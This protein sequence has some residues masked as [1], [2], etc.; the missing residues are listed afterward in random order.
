M[1]ILVSLRR[2]FVVPFVCARSLFALA[3]LA[4]GLA[5]FAQSPAQAPPAPASP[6]P[7]SPPAAAAATTPT[8]GESTPALAP[9]PAPVAPPPSQIAQPAAP[10]TTAELRTITAE[11]IK[12][13]LVGK[14][15]FL[16]GGYLDDTLHFDQHGQ[17]AGN[18]PKGSYTLNLVQ[19]DK[20][21]L[22]KHKL[23]LEGVRYGLHYLGSLPSEDPLETADK[24]KITPKKKMLRITIDRVEPVTKKIKKPA[25]NKKGAPAPPTEPAP[26]VPAAPAVDPNKVLDE[27][28]NNVF[29]HGIDQRMIAALPDFWKIYFIPPSAAAAQPHDS[30]LR[31]S[32]V[33]K[34]ARLVSAFE[35]P[36]N[37]YAQSGGVAGMATYHVVVGSDGKP[38]EVTVGRP[39]GFGLDENAVASI[40]KAS[41]EPAIKDGKPVPVVLDLIVQFRIY[42]KRTSGTVP[43]ADKVEA[44]KVA[45]ALP[46]PYSANQPQD[47]TKL[48]QDSVK[49]TQDS[50]KQ[51]SDNVK[52]P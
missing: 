45:P 2:D 12:Q 10:Q 3:A 41:F 20:V 46:G 36:S 42:S 8:A 52:Q 32:A 27:A 26:A 9:A 40:R 15:L 31:Q 22:E 23:Q 28:I 13:N 14:T 30:M 47:N 49:Q 37:E 7:S 19:I 48:A 44:G 43:E 39:I 25:R 17:I 6:D 29:S 1:R 4:S 35:P 50:A 51:A 18:S 21:R 5:V 24:V 34:K 11:E 16:R 33:D 38:G